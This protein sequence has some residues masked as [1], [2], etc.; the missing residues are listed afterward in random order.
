MSWFMRDSDEWSVY[1]YILYFILLHFITTC[2]LLDFL[3]FMPVPLSFA[4]LYFSVTAVTLMTYSV[5]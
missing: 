2:I 4:S 5:P 1:C 3:A